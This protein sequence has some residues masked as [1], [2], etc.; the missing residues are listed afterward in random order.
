[1]H[2]E[3]LYKVNRVRS[4]IDRVRSKVDRVRSRFPRASR[5]LVLY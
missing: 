2:L 5:A 1:M 3:Y 4:K